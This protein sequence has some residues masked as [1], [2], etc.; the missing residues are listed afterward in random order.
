MTI[1]FADHLHDELGT[2][3]LGYIP[4]GGADFGEVL[5]VARAVGDGD[6]D[7]FHDAWQG[8]ALRH[9]AAAEA[10]LARGHRTSA[11]DCLLRAAVAH[12]ASYHP[13]FGAPPD[14]RLIAAF[15]RQI[16]AFDRGLALSDPPVLPL[17]IPFAGTTMPAYLIPAAGRAGQTRPL[18]ICNNGYDATLTDSYFATAVA[19]SRRGYH[20]LIFDGPGQGEMLY[21]QGIP[22]RPDWNVVV[23]AVV[24]FALTLDG[25]DPDRIVLSGWSLGG[26]LAP[27][28]AAA[29]RRL[30]ACI[31]DPPTWSIAAGFRAPL[32]R[33]GASPEAAA[34]LRRLDDPMVERLTAFVTADRRLRWKV[35]QRGLWVHGVPT[36]RDYLRVAEDFTLDGQIGD[37]RCP[38]LLTL[39]ADDP[40]AA[41]AQAFFDA[42]RAPKTLIRFDAAEGAGGHCEMNNRSLLNR[43]TFDWLDETLGM[44]ATARA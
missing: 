20:A 16:A 33:L 26:H 7:A 4:Y 32:I 3:A 41:G 15:R 42:L 28:A 24:D 36:V 37:I 12:A 9:E 25:V 8:A 21:L 18:V 17:R 38:M 29:E 22:L 2:W 43:R 19:A 6:D 10:A 30:A 31:A 23:A 1:L 44:T 13:L 34:D 39:A 5:A 40:Q 14:P 27:R 35:I 11:R